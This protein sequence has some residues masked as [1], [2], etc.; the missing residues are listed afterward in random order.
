MLQLN[1]ACQLKK[2][3]EIKFLQLPGFLLHFSLQEQ[4]KARNGAV[5]TASSPAPSAGQGGTAIEQPS[6]IQ[7]NESEAAPVVV[8]QVSESE[9]P[10]VVNPTVGGLSSSETSLGAPVASAPSSASHPFQTEFSSVSSSPLPP[11]VIP[12]GLE[13]DFEESDEGS[14][15]SPRDSGYKFPGDKSLWAKVLL[16]TLL[17]LLSL[18][19][20]S[21]SG[22][23]SPDCWWY[24]FWSY[25]VFLDQETVSFACLLSFFM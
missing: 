7:V 12:Q 25:F 21:W 9:I 5:R 10:P 17:F 19:F 16:L 3:S 24:C 15:G 14:T 1:L 6:S 8:P 4:L 23:A 13:D 2:G 22:F 20:L 11:R 18:G